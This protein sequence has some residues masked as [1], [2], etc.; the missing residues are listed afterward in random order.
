MEQSLP[1]S[2]LVALYAASIA[3]IALAAVTVFVLLRFKRQLDR[4]VTMV[5]RVEAEIVPLAR[6]TRLAMD[7]V[8]DVSE[9]VHRQWLALERVFGTVRRFTGA[10]G[11]ALL[12]PNLARVGAATFLRALWTG[13]RGASHHVKT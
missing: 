2:L 3:V 6:E 10:A 11:G 9:R 4:V 1:T 7:R 5:E 13:R 12:A 8:R